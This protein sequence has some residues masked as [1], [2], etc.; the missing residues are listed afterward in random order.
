MVPKVGLEPTQLAPLPPQDSV[1]TSFTTSA[2]AQTRNRILPNTACARG[3]ASVETL[4]GAD[5]NLYF[6][7]STSAPPV[8]SSVAAS[9]VSRVSRAVPELPVRV[10]TPG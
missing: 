8:P 10:P 3:D 5:S 9:L 2:L 6:L 7:L 4:L 1:S